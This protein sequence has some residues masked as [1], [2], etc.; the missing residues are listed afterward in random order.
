MSSSRVVPRWISRAVPLVALISIFSVGARANAQAMVQNDALSADSFADPRLEVSYQSDRMENTSAPLAPEVERG[1]NSFRQAVGAEKAGEWVGWVDRRT[2]RLDYA[3]GPGLPWL[4]G[5]GNRLATQD[6]VN[7]FGVNAKS[8]LSTLEKIARDF[9]TPLS[10]A[11][12]IN[13]KDLVLSTGRSGR[14]SDFLWFLDFDVIRGGLPVDGARVFFRINNGNLIQFGSEGLASP[15]IETP[16]ARLDRSH[17]L[18]IATAAFGKNAPAAR[19]VDSKLQLVQFALDLPGRAGQFD[20][21]RGVRWTPVWEI[22]VER[23]GGAPWL[24]RIDAV[25]GEVMILRDL[26][27][28]AAAQVHGGVRAD[29]TVGETDLPMPFADVAP[30]ATNSAGLYDYQ[31]G[32]I[33]STLAGTFVTIKDLN[34]GTISQSADASGNIDFL[35]NTGTDCTTPGSGGTGNTASARTQFYWVNRIKEVGRGWLPLNSWLGQNLQVEVNLNKVCNAY[36]HP[37]TKD[38]NFFISGI[39]PNSNIPCGNS[40]ELPGVSL[41]E[42]GHG[43][44]QFDGSGGSDAASKESYADITSILM[45]HN[46]CTGSGFLV[47][48]PCFGYGDPCT[49]CS[50]IRDIDW[51]KRE[52]NVPHTVANYVQPVCKPDPDLSGGLC[53]R[54]EHCTSYIA[55]E[56]MWD[57]VNRDLPT[58][59]SAK[60]WNTAERIWYLSRQ[61]AT[62]AWKCDKSNATWASDG[63]TNGSMFRVLRAADDDDGNLANG[64]PH[65]GAIFAA[66]DRHEIACAADAGANVTFAGCVPPVVPTLT[67]A[68]GANQNSLSWTSSG[69]GKVYDV[70]R[71]EGGCDSGFAKIAND[72]AGLA[73]NDPNVSSSSQ[74]AYQVVAQP[75]ANEACA[76]AP[77]VCKVVTSLEKTDLWSKDKLWD[78]GLEPDPATAANNMW[79]SR[80]IWI[81]NVDDG[82]TSHQNPEFG[83]TNFVNVRFYNKGTVKAKNVTVALYWAKASAGLAWPADWHPFGSAVTDID[84]SGTATVV[85]PWLPAFKGH[86]CLLARILSA[87]DPL[88]AE[89]AD[90]NVNVRK[91]NNLVW[92]NVNVV[93]LVQFSAFTATMVV[94]NFES[95]TAVVKLSFLD[96]LDPGVLNPFLRRGRVTVDLGPALFDLWRRGGALGSNVAIVGS[97][98][99][100]ILGT[101]AWI[102]MTMSPRQEFPIDLNF[103]DTATGTLQTRTEP[104]VFEVRQT[105]IRSERV[106]GGVTYEIES[107]ALR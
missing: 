69:A 65:G 3:E 26:R 33:S 68:A 25:S 21:G 94:R 6:L 29:A 89:V 37:V 79:E 31:G 72:V 87:Q 2:G 74:Y 57:L 92:R 11:L 40:G 23:V 28:F 30:G 51:A 13:P 45:T 81:R 88:P 107:P 66:L 34:C 20:A 97:T 103:Q 93:D 15:G 64:T 73:F 90:P 105:N 102:Q 12:G 56:S 46:S 17:A 19:V 80:D 84:P 70:Y 83:Q 61:T 67:V 1:W 104:N 71:S 95:A 106:Q 60:A 10:G 55:S 98:S 54:E 78:T 16:T 77:T 75:S 22:T 53:G 43:L 5:F 47:D 52:S 24:A 85:V 42:Y 82:L 59:G 91:S 32:A 35:S 50:G 14:Q 86:V 36:W 39:F 62:N 4:P 96:R 101:G 99:I 100:Q 76:A 9:L 41:H 8:D 63:C 27:E 18:A 49:S 58:P 7:R 44:D 38:L 48:I